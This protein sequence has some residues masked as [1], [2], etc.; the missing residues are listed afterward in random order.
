M[1]ST[2][3]RHLRFSPAGV[4][5]VVALVFAMMGGAFAANNSSNSGGGATASAKGKP[6]PR[7]KPG[8][9]GPTGPAGPQGSAG[10][11]GK[12]G[13]NGTNGV[14]GTNGAPGPEGTFGS[15]PL[16][17]GQ[18]LTG[19]WATSGGPNATTAEGDLSMVPI[20]FPIQVSAVPTVIVQ[21]FAGSQLGLI[22]VDGEA[23]IYAPN[24]SGSEIEGFEDRA[25]AVPAG[26][27]RCDV[28]VHCL[29][30]VAAGAGGEDHE[31]GCP[32]EQR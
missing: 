29:R 17:I 27:A 8:K 21:L 9:R 25:G 1:F 24:G 12:D 16:P 32:D 2:I 4:I 30:A 31:A 15:K 10:V 22:V 18:S 7:G 13:K 23:K 6:G 5:A 19:A 11:N 20:S 3:R 28:G 14:N 26:P